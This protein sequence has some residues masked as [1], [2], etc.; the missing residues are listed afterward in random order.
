MTNQDDSLVQRVDELF[1]SLA[2]TAANLNKASKE[3]SAVIDHIDGV[4]QRLKFRC[5]CMD[6][7]DAWRPSRC[8]VTDRSIGLRTSVTAGP[9]GNHGPYPQEREWGFDR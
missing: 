6:R 1:P 4:L 8:Q 3:L 2:A 9:D 5:D 7:S